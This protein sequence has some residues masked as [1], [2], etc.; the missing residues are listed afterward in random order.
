MLHDPRKLLDCV[1]ETVQ[2]AERRSECEMKG[3]IVRCSLE[4]FTVPRRRSLPVTP[5]RRRIP[6]G[7]GI[8]R[9]LRDRGFRSRGRA[10]P[11][12][13]EE[14]GR[15]DQDDAK[16]ARLHSGY[17]SCQLYI[18]IIRRPPRLLNTLLMA[19]VL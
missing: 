13:P 2:L 12:S 16:S 18:D 3:E 4:R 10:I 8:A 7:T 6:F 9:G 11:A 19:C 14:R 1:C 5:L 17:C 15:S